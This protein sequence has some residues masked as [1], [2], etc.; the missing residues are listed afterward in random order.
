MVWKEMHG[1]LCQLP[2]ETSNSVFVSHNLS[3]TT[4]SSKCFS[5]SEISQSAHEGSPKLYFFVHQPSTHHV[6]ENLFIPKESRG[7]NASLHHVVSSKRYTPNCYK[8]VAVICVE[9]QGFCKGYGH[10]RAQP[11]L[12]SARILQY[13]SIKSLQHAAFQIF[14]TTRAIY[15]IIIHCSQMM[16]LWWT[17]NTQSVR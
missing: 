3:K 13:P 7:S 6:T 11:P 9:T 10:P 5:C 15:V 1:S 2:E 4:H 8:L 16:M 17:E 14:S 12:A